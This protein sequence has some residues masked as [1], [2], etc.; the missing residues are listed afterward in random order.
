MFIG[1]RIVNQ[2]Q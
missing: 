2:R 1:P